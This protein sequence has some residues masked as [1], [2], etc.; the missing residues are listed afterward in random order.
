MQQISLVGNWLSFWSYGPPADGL[1]VRPAIRPLRP[2]EPAVGGG[3]ACWQDA[4]L[5]HR[6]ESVGV[7]NGHAAREHID[8]ARLGGE[9]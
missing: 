7:S 6:G 4:L 9:T 5:E 1:V 3:S 8:R 2:A